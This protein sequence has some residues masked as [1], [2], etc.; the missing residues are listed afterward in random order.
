[1]DLALLS[2]SSVRDKICK[3]AGARKGSK[4]QHSS[5]EE[6][7]EEEEEGSSGGRA[8]SRVN[9]SL[10][11]TANISDMTTGHKKLNDIFTPLRAKAR[12]SFNQ[13]SDEL[14]TAMKVVNGVNCP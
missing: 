6:E 4:Q 13:G 1:M 11:V 2:R 12:E 8:H 5:S 14:K 7:E 10:N 9:V 3:C